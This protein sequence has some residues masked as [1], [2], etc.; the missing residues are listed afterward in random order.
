MKDKIRCPHCS[1]ENNQIKRG[2]TASGNIWLYWVK[3]YSQENN[4]IQ[5]LSI[6]KNIKI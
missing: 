2:K 4:I 3:K 5:N 6:D 1:R